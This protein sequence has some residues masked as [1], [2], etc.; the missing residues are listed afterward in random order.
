[1]LCLLERVAI[2][3]SVKGSDCSKTSYG[4]VSEAGGGGGA[5]DEAGSVGGREEN[6]DTCVRRDVPDVS[7]EVIVLCSRAMIS[8]GECV[9]E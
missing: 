9:K 4:R 8:E 3:R 2:S 7:V 6:D 1:M 5:V